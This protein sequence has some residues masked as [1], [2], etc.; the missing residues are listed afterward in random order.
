M[1]RITRRTKRTVPVSMRGLMQRINRRLRPDGEQMKRS[2]GARARAE[3]GRFWIVGESG[4]VL[5]DVNPVSFGR[6]LGVLRP[7]ERVIE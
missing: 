3:L 1:R 7:W 2:V 5:E 4:I 6:K